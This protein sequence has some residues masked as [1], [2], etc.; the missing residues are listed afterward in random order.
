MV[1][2]I[3]LQYKAAGTSKI[4]FFRIK[5]S[6]IGKFQHI[7]GTKG[8][9]VRAYI[10][11]VCTRSK[12]IFPA[13]YFS[14]FDHKG[15]LTADP[16][17]FG[18][19]RTFCGQDAFFIQ[20]KFGFIA[21]VEFEGSFIEIDFGTCF[22]GRVVG[23]LQDAAIDFA[24]LYDGAADISG[25]YKVGDEAEIIVC[26]PLLCILYPSQGGID[27]LEGVIAEKNLGIADE[28]SVIGVFGFGGIA[29]NDSPVVDRDI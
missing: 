15:V 14:V 7:I 16:A 10:Y 24:A 13:V 19:Y 27:G 25:Q 12:G 26:D 8:D 3:S 20:S 6:I 29:D 21:G 22:A 11:A 2:F 4:S 23:G 17:F 1:Q 5:S 9:S 28:D 18:F